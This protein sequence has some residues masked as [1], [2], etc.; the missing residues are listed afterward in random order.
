MSRSNSTSSEE[1]SD[2]MEIETD[3]ETQYTPCLFCSHLFKNTAEAISHCNADHNFDLVKL[4]SHFNMDCYDFIKLV[5]YI[6]IH[7][8]EASVIM[9]ATEPL[10]KNE[11]YMK[12]I[13][14][15]D[16][17]LMYDFDDL[18]VP[19]PVKVPE[20]SISSFH[21]NA[22]DGCVTLS[23]KHFSELQRTIQQLTLEDHVR[24]SSYCEAIK[25]NSATW[26]GKTVLDLGCGTAILSMFAATA[27]A[28]KVISIDQSDIIYHAMDIVRENNLEDKIQLVKG[29]L[30]DTE[31][32]QKCVDVILSEWMG[33]FLLFEGMLD[34][35]IYARDHHLAP[36][37]LLLPN[38]CS[39]SF[40]GVG[41]LARHAEL[42][43][44]WNDVYG[45]RMT[46]LK[47]E[48]IKEAT[49]EV[50]PEDKIITT[51]CILTELDLYKCTTNS[52]DFTS[53][54]NFQ[55]T[56]D[57]LLTGLVG[58]FDIFF[59]LPHPISFSTSPFSQ[60]THWK[61]TLFLLEEP[62][63]VKKDDVLS[64]KITCQRN[65]KDVRSLI[66]TISVLGKKLK[67]IIN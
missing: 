55:V 46:C 14:P 44:F 66:V 34:S 19:S 67:Y 38:R 60:P 49:I 45:Y 15:D 39:I 20:N 5:N 23:E 11:E 36:G 41:D 59:D 30:E 58:Y 7:Q 42:V 2:W 8:P 61:Q 9:A 18:E 64:G 10:W 21:V 13:K 24:T 32:P 6:H 43:G 37:G 47:N 33:Y 22:E 51:A 62:V 65:H 26:K 29:R 53:N 57:G 12:P 48:V 4:K 25:L 16:P 3:D 54:F 50:I 17:W 27:G 35:V 1:D 56:K 52:V 28:E 31:L 63:A 40:V